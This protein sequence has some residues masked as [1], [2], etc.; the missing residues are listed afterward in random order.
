M[1]LWS[2]RPSYR[3][4]ALKSLLHEDRSLWEHWTRDAA[5]FP[6]ALHAVWQFH[7]ARH[8]EKLTANWQRWFHKGYIAQLDTI[9]SRIARDGPVGSADVG[10]GEMR[11]KGNWCRTALATGEI[12]EVDLK[13]AAG[14]RRKSYLFAESLHEVPPEPPA[15]AARRLRILSPS[16]PPLRDRARAK[17]LFGFRYRIE[18]FV[19]EPKRVFGYYV[20]P[21]LEGD[22]LVGRF[23]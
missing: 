9:L 19:P 13:G 17:F 2:L 1:I 14:Q 6:V 22:R 8:A 11:G 4:A 5:I 3:P 7:F 20:F 16:D 23:D 15:Q 10:A 18:V 12:V 21:A